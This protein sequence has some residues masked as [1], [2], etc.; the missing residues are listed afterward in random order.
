VSGVPAAAATAGSP[1]HGRL[2]L[3]LVI[4]AIL[5]LLPLFALPFIAHR[6]F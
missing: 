3:L 2:T 4:P 1:D 5:L 6:R